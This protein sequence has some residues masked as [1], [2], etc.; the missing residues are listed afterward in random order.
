MTGLTATGSLAPLLLAFGVLLGGRAAVASAQEASPAT[1]E[2]RPCVERCGLTSVVVSEYGDAAG[3]GMIES[4]LSIGLLDHSG[5]K[6]VAGRDHVLVFDQDGNFLRRVGRRG[7]GPGEMLELSSVTI[8]DDGVFVVIDRRRGVIM[9]FDWT[10]TLLHE[11][12]ARGWTPTGLA[13]IPLGGD[14]AVYEANIR[15][16]DRIGYPLHLINLKNGEIEKSF[17]SL[18]GEYDPDRERRLV[19]TAA[20]GPEDS[21]WMARLYAYWIELWDPDNRLLFSM[22]RDVDW[23]ADALVDRTGTH[24]NPAL[25]R[26]PEPV[27]MGVLADDS[28]LWVMVHRSDDRWEQASRYDDQQRLDTFIEVIDWKRGRVIGSQRFDE[29][30][31]PWLGPGLVGQAVITPEGSLQMRV[32]RLELEAASTDDLRLSRHG[33]DGSDS[34]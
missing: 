34:R 33:L 6:Y 32:S 12:R 3:P 11:V 20:R 17:G 16:A 29:V 14:L 4:E 19:V 30:Y 10:G 22:R 2:I 18:N 26:E 7:E 1:I 31:Y 28:L 15:T 5:R 8:A 27:L 24:G 13:L 9:K 25:A 23:F 21:I